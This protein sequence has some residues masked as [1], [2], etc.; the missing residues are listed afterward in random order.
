MFCM[1]NG[2]ELTGFNVEFSVAL[3]RIIIAYLRVTSNEDIPC[4]LLLRLPIALEEISA[5]HRLPVDF[6]KNQRLQKCLGCWRLTGNSVPAVYITRLFFFQFV[7][8]YYS[9][10][11]VVE[12]LFFE[13]YIVLLIFCRRR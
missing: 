5:N 12:M 8:M 11:I 13:S 2:R 4:V 10:Q 9:H 3:L 6:R 7:D 1:P